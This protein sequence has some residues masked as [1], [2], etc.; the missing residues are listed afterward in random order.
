M[1]SGLP[2]GMHPRMLKC[3]LLFTE[4]RPLSFPVVAAHPSRLPTP[5]SLDDPVSLGIRLV[6]CCRFES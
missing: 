4:R 1:A 6:M 2:A 3:I 5:P